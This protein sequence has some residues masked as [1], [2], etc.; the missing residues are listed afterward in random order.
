MKVW[1]VGEIDDPAKIPALARRELAAWT[2]TD[3]EALPGLRLI[4][5]ELVTNALVH[6]AAEWVRMLLVPERGFWR[7]TVID[8]GRNGLVPHPRVSEETD[9][10]GRGLRVVHDATGGLWGTYRTLVGERVVWALVP[11]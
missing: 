8:P 2:G 4:A 5:S 6:A 3:H 9:E 10:S 1:F 11:R 7:L